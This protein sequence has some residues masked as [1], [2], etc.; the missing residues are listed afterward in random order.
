MK[1]LVYATPVDTIEELR[2]RIEDVAAEIKGNAE[3]IM[4]TQQSLIRRAH[5][6]VRNGGRHFEALL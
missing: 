6:C 3:M 2:N 5:A 1:Q 4:R